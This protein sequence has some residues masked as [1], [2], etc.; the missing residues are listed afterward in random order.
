MKRL[1]IRKKK[2][3]KNYI[4]KE[5]GYMWRFYCTF[6]IMVQQLNRGSKLYSIEKGVAKANFVRI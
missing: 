1:K 3:N 6:C 5:I 4:W 2:S